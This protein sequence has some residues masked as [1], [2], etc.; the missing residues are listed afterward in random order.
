MPLKQQI[1]GSD[2]NQNE[3]NVEKARKN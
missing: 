3:K 1:F 2:E